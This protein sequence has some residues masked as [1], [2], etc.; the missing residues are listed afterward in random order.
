MVAILAAVGG[1]RGFVTGPQQGTATF[2]T[3]PAV[4]ELPE[5]ILQRRYAGGEMSREA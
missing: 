4:P 1:I 5:E 2:T 3:P